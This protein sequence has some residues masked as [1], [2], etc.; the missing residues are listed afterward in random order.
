MGD[1]CRH[2]LRRRKR[3]RGH[4][5]NSKTI[6]EQHFLSIW[7]AVAEQLSTARDLNDGEAYYGARRDFRRFLSLYLNIEVDRE[8]W[9]QEK[10]R[11][12]E[13]VTE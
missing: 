7:N 5:M 4:T 9:K 10:E 6:T 3:K 2:Y 8:Q 13:A 11:F 1:E 12:L